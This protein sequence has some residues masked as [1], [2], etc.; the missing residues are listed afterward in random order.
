MCD[1]FANL[2]SFEF[3]WAVF[4]PLFMF[5]SRYLLILHRNS[6]QQ[7]SCLEMYNQWGTAIQQALCFSTH[8]SHSR[9]RSPF[10]TT[11]RKINTISEIYFL[12]RRNIICVL[13][14][15]VVGRLRPLHCLLKLY[16][17]M[18]HLCHACLRC[19]QFRRTS[20]NRRMAWNE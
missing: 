1:C 16:Q 18:L 17:L 4:T 11:W 7:I 14:S 2:H 6:A 19:P 8:R 5:I 15:V 10:Q 20:Y 9:I 3:R 12:I 13:H